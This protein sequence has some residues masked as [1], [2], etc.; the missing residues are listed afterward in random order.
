MHG[1]SRTANRPDPKIWDL[2]EFTKL[3]TE[4]ACRVIAMDMCMWGK[5][6]PDSDE[7]GQPK[8]PNKDL[9]YKKGLH[10]YALLLARQ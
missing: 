3:Q 6:P 7:P 9:R 10:L 2:P 5:A 8:A 4:T 1:P